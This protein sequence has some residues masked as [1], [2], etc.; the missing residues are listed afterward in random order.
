ML[1]VS[2]E[3]NIKRD[4]RMGTDIPTLTFSFLLHPIYPQNSTWPF[5]PSLFYSNQFTP[6]IVLGLVEGKDCIGAF[7]DISEALI[8][9]FSHLI[10]KADVCQRGGKEKKE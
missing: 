10:F 7:G 1:R 3:C 5:F 8:P 2:I 9:S 6:R 4:T